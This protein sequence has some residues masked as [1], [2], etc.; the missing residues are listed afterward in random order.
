LAERALAKGQKKAV[1]DR[2]RYIFHGRV[3][4]QADA[5]RAGGRDF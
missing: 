1:F 5:A 3:K 2:G 4:A